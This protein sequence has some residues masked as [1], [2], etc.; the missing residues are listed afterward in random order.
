MNKF[1]EEVA[2]AFASEKDLREICFVFPNR[3][4]SIFFRR[5]LGIAVGKTIFSPRLVTIDE[6]FQELSGLRPADKIELLK[7][8]YDCYVEVAPA[9]EGVGHETFD[10]FI[11]WGDILL[12]DFDDIDKYLVRAG[13]L[14][15]NIKDLK[16]LSADYGFLSQGQKE[17]IAQFCTNFDPEACSPDPTDK[18]QMF[19]RM[20]DVLLPLYERFREKLGS[21]GLAYPGMMYRKVAEDCDLSQL[22]ARHPQV[23][24]V[25]L[26]ALNECEKALLD[27]IRKEGF[28]DFYWDFYGEMVCNPYNRSSLFISE[29]VRRYPS[30][31]ELPG[32][33]TAPEQHFEVIAVPSAVGQTRKASQILADL[34]AGGL[35]ED[36]V[37][38]A[39]VLPDES[40]LFPMLG[41]VPGS[42]DKIN[43]TMGYPL[44]ASDVSGFFSI[45]E[46]LQQNARVK[47]GSAQ[48]YHKDVVDILE[49]P[50]F[51]KVSGAD[52]IQSV[53]EDIINSNRIYVTQ[54]FLAEKGSEFATIFRHV[55]SAEDIAG[56]Q[57]SVIWLVQEGQEGSEKEFLSRYC[58]AVQRLDSLDLDKASMAP[59]TWFRLLSQ[60]VAL[61]SIPYRG[62]PLDGLQIMGPLET[63]ALDFKNII[64]LSVGEGVFP[65]KRV[66]SSFIPYNLRVGFG[67]P[68][69]ELQDSISAYYFYRSIF[70]AENI[71]LLYDSRTE[72]LQNGEESRYIK[73]LRYHFR[74]PMTEKVVSYNLAAGA[75][76]DEPVQVVKTPEVMEKLRAKFVID[77]KVLSPTSLNAY[78][79]CRLRFYYEYVLGLREED[80]V[81][82]ELDAGL[83]GSIYHKVMEDIYRKRAGQKVLKEELIALRRDVPALEELIDAAFMSEAK[84]TSIEGNNLILKSVILRYVQRTLE[85]DEGLCPFTLVGAESSE[86][87]KWP[88]KNAGAP[89]LIY[90]KID[91]LD[92]NMPD[93]V[94]V[95]DYKTGSVKNHTNCSDVEAIFKSSDQD[96]PYVAFQ[97]YLYALLMGENHPGKTYSP[98]IYALRDIF[99][100]LPE[101]QMI[102]E[103]NMN[104]FK[105]KLGALLEEIFD[106]DVPFGPN[107]ENEKVCDYCNFKKICRKQ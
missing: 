106:P 67:L 63:R 105:E 9:P 100:G 76:P 49:H 78:I 95:V 83:F 1:L 55:S 12:R 71:Y 37:E 41:A 53:K 40:L 54:D 46:R 24:F 21:A 33:D 62:E 17:A 48:F 6:L 25:G 81:N 5:Y 75:A 56:Y 32:V 70:R 31:K 38:T 103:D 73:Q 7:I 99:G 93:T 88:V 47:G 86:I 44:S 89:V 13:Q 45:V 16:D 39:L 22:K 90:G 2:K 51:E 79:N 23:V 30:K 107:T 61:L 102:T 68:T 14:L 58:E 35:M 92:S 74:V 15:V 64:M 20:W 77:K 42:V 87:I 94:R 98:C 65:S 82:E 8:L 26:N 85:E 28:G 34:Q 52:L 91:R 18:K 60:Y 59:A 72:G 69:Y 96:R 101:A 4:S 11:F 43:V 80:T 50:Y 84:I 104:L 3:R 36:P 97:L 27:A 29:N 10:K 66:S 57:I 19:L